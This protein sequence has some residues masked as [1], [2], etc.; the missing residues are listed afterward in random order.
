[1]WMGGCF[2]GRLRLVWIGEG[3]EV[4]V[5]W[6]FGNGDKAWKEMAT[7]KRSK[8]SVYGEVAGVRRKSQYITR[9]ERD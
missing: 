1:M 5:A 2:G 7:G 6:A 3:L 4:L 8:K 9:T